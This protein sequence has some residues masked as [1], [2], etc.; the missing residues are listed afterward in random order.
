[1]K[2]RVFDQNFESI[3]FLTNVANIVIVKVYQSVIF[4]E[5][6]LGNYYNRL[7][8]SDFNFLLKYLKTSSDRRRVCT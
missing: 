6:R 1:M 7:I 8:D 5:L 4:N 2:A 3:H